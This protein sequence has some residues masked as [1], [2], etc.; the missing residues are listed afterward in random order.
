MDKGIVAVWII[1]VISVASLLGFLAHRHQLKQ[2]RMASM[3]YCETAYHG[4]VT[5]YW[6]KCQET[7]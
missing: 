3:G 7:K 6:Q 4:S 5:L 2:E 1:A